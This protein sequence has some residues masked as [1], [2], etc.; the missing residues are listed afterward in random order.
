MV[1]IVKEKLSGG[2]DQRKARRLFENLEE[3]VAKKLGYLRDHEMAG[4]RDNERTT[5]RPTS[6][7]A[8]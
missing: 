8:T 3:P 6:L 2:L 7:T 4:M 5:R 1:D